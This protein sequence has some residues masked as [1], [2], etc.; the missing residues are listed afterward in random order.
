LNEHVTLFGHHP[1]VARLL[2]ALDIFALPSQTEGLSI[3]LLEACASELA[4]VATSVGGN[5][6]II[7]D[8]QTGLLVPPDDNDA[9][10]VAIQRMLDSPALRCAMGAR[11]REW[12]SQNA[13]DEALESAYER[14]YREALNNLRTA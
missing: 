8:E 12:V 9:L 14:C 2:P 7:Q 1:Q 11:A 3:A 5:P 13:S 10:R 4:I 6:D